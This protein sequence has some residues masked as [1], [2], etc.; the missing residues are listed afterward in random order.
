MADHGA[1]GTQYTDTY[2]IEGPTPVMCVKGA[3]KDELD[4]P[5][6]RALYGFTRNG[7]LLADDAPV[8]RFSDRT[9]GEYEFIFSGHTPRLILMLGA[10]ADENAQ[11]QDHITAS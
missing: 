4:I 8:L 9:T 5:V 7:E 3:I 10:F 2:V 6:R 1:I 11:V